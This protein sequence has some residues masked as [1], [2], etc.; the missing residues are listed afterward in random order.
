MSLSLPYEDRNF[1]Y[2]VKIDGIFDT[3]DNA[4]TGNPW[5]VD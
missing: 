4:E 5:E 1:E 2:N 3:K